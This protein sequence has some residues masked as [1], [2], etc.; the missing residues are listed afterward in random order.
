MSVTIV[1]YLQRLEEL[2][3]AAVVMA[4]RSCLCEFR[5]SAGPCEH[6]SWPVVFNVELASRFQC[7]VSDYCT[8][9]YF[10][11]IITFVSE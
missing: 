9:C 5:V 4:L 10:Q 2:Q 6:A 3:K 11:I 8:K 1:I 7:R